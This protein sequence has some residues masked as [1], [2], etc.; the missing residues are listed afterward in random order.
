MPNVTKWTKKYFFG[1]RKS[2]NVAVYISAPSW[3][4]G[5]Y[6]GFGYL[7]N[8]NEHY[9]LDSYQQKQHVFKLENGKYEIITEARNKNMFD[10]LSED[11][12]LSDKIKNNLWKFCELVKT[13]YNLKETAEVLGRGG[14]H[15]T[16]NPC[17]DLIKNAEETKRINDIVLPA[18]FDEIY[19]IFESK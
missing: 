2:D 12:D 1:T 5:W 16:V 7:G 4:C 8:K 10:C 9:H 19:N 15:Y 3:D 6:W 11:Y 17:A 14:S 18:I 13:A